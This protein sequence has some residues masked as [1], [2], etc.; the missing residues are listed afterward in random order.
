MSP[1]SLRSGWQS[2]CLTVGAI[3][4][5]SIG[6]DKLAFGGVLGSNNYGLSEPQVSS[7]ITAPSA[8]V[9]VSNEP[10]SE[11]DSESGQSTD[12]RQRSEPDIKTTT[13]TSSTNTQQSHPHHEWPW[14][15]HYLV[16][17]ATDANYSAV[18]VARMRA[19]HTNQLLSSSDGRRQG[20]IVL[21]W[22]SSFGRVPKQVKALGSDVLSAVA[23]ANGLGA[24]VD[25]HGRGRFFCKTNS[26]D[27]C[28]TLSSAVTRGRPVTAVEWREDHDQALFI[29]D[30]GQVHAVGVKVNVR[31]LDKNG[32]EDDSNK[33]Y[34]NQGVDSNNQNSDEIEKGSLLSEEDNVQHVELV[35]HS[36][37]LR[38]F[39]QLGKRRARATKVSCGG[40]H[41]AILCDDGDVYMLQSSRKMEHKAKMTN[42]KHLSGDDDTNR[43]ANDTGT[44][45]A[46]L[47]DQAV[48]TT[49]IEA[50]RVV[51]SQ[52]PS[53]PSPHSPRMVDV[54]CSDG[55]VLALDSQGSLYAMGDDRWIQLGRNA[56]PWVRNTA[57]SSGLSFSPS[58]QQQ[59][60]KQAER[61][62]QTFA[63][64]S[65]FDGL[66]GGAV[67]AGASHS[68]LLVVD[69][70]LFTCGFNQFGQLGHHNYATFAP[71][72]PVADVS[73]RVTSVAAGGNH[74]C[75]T[76]SPSGVLRCI[77]A[78]ES[79]QLGT[80]GL[81]PSATWRKVKYNGQA[82]K[83]TFVYAGR[84]TTVVVAKA[85][86][87][88][89]NG[90]KKRKE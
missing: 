5:G 7:T 29:D 52:G 46:I 69:G 57:T 21:A 51:V 85:D 18:H 38:L 49:T 30:I 77:G 40:D 32:I 62:S 19:A 60:E 45:S 78:N 75:V 90:E 53:S 83:P 42:D 56:T 3:A 80:G 68:A 16:I 37:G 48:A 20:G 70:T 67:A 23:G 76:T 59:Q 87:N 58:Q 84:A 88:G 22:G 65:L 36:T 9:D 24:A 43:P 74:T 8:A 89:D 35:R 82:V 12:G 47:P 31:H 27:D 14:W 64:A 39:G 13:T 10:G 26:I 33:Q 41:C 63:K 4:A 1:S 54:S 15:Y 73:L 6:A 2:L 61:T 11:S 79:G 71:P 81:Q 86:A 17:K 72:A 66:V 44:E 28:V 55:H 34:A 25:V 50:R